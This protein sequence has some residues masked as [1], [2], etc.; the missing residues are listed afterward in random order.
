MTQWLLIS[1]WVFLCDVPNENALGCI[2]NIN[3][4][5]LPIASP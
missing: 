5:Q 4:N 1:H 3:F 2:K